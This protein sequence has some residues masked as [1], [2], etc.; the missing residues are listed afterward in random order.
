MINS[1]HGKQMMKIACQKG[2]ESFLLMR[3]FYC[4][5]SKTK[6]M[7]VGVMRIEEEEEAVRSN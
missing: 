5:V 6:Q 7:V 1:A 3:K 2:K 4:N